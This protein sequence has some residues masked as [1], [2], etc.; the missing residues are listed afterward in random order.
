M[1]EKLLIQ[2]I[3]N[4]TEDTNLLIRD[5]L[6]PKHI[7]LQKMVIYEDIPEIIKFLKKVQKVLNFKKPYNTGAMKNYYDGIEQIKR[8]I[9]D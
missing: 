9:Y 4:L 2:Y 5:N 1:T 3:K 8:E 7:E 6:H